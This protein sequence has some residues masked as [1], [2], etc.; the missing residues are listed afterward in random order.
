MLAAFRSLVDRV[1][2]P[3]P[4]SPPDAPLDD[5]RLRLATA[6]LLAEVMRA[7]ATLGEAE[8]RSAVAALQAKFELPDDAVHALL[9]EALDTARQSTD[10]HAFTSALNARLDDA[11][12]IRVVEAM[13]AVAY[14]DGTLAAH[15]RHLLWRVAD[16]LHVPHG[17]YV[18]ARLRAQAAAGG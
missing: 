2:A 13:W 6:V 17:A 14:A 4:G 8:R 5:T 11:Q 7:D 15:E 3:P 16:L 18:H 10:L 9:D 12:K 1:L